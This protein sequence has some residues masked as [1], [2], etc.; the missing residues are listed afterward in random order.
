MEH[1]IRE[2]K[3]TQDLRVEWNRK[4]NETKTEPNYRLTVFSAIQNKPY[5]QNLLGALKKPSRSISIPMIPLD[6]MPHLC[7]TQ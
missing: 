1:K 6:P 7:N 5:G 3:G 4:L 2:W